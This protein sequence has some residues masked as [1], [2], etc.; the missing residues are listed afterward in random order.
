MILVLEQIMTSEILA[1]HI[2][3]E[4][5]GMPLFSHFFDPDL[6]KDPSTIQQRMRA[7][8]IRLLHE[9]GNYVVYSVLV[10]KETPEAKELLKKFADRVEKVYPEGLKRGQGNFSHFVI[11]ENIVKEVFLDEK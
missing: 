11:L 6:K 3:E 10:K 9:L 1:C 4:E 8:E 5:T 2:L 7:R